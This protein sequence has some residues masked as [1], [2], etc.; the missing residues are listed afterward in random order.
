M[1]WHE[2]HEWKGRKMVGG[3]PISELRCLSSSLETND[4]RA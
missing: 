2:W 4:E 3:M 1:E